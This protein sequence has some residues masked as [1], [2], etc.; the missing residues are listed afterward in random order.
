MHG[1]SFVVPSLKEQ[2]FLEGVIFFAQQLAGPPVCFA[3]PSPAH[4]PH[5]AG[6]QTSAAGP[7]IDFV[8]AV[9]YHDVPSNDPVGHVLAP[10]V[11]GGVG[12]G[13]GAGVGAAFGTGTG[14]SMLVS[15][16]NELGQYLGWWL[17]LASH[18]ASVQVG[19]MHL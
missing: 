8:P 12:G 9:V 14:T 11:G 15:R 3:H 1:A 19:K 4:V 13:V 6:Q 18:H 17:Q 10:A 5:S 7:P 16:Q 2:R